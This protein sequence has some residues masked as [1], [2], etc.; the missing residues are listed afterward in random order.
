MPEYGNWSTLSSV[1]CSQSNWTDLNRRKNYLLL[2]PAWISK[3]S[4]TSL[5]PLFGVAHREIMWIRK[6]EESQLRKRHRGTAQER[7]VVQPGV[8]A[9]IPHFQSYR[10]H[11]RTALNLVRRLHRQTLILCPS[12]ANWGAN[13]SRISS[14]HLRLQRANRSA[15]RM[16]PVHDSECSTQ[17]TLKPSPVLLALI[18]LLHQICLR[19]RSSFLKAFA[20]F[21]SPVVSE[22]KKEVKGCFGTLLQ[23][24]LFL[25]WNCLRISNTLNA[26]Y[27]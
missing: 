19:S 16:R 26:K 25:I 8:E 24:S 21:A 14:K 15:W 11:E 5:Y 22:Y 10:M 6:V 9:R 4:Q 7:Q 20:K 18:S 13:M 12:V 2:Y 23:F 27:L 3:T 17:T 1:K